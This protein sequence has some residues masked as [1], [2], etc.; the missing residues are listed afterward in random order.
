MPHANRN[1]CG[2]DDELI[3]DAFGR[4]V[5][6]NS[7]LLPDDLIDVRMARL[8]DAPPICDVGSAAKIPRCR[9]GSKVFRSLTL[10]SITQKIQAL[11]KASAL[12]EISRVRFHPE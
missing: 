7:G 1:F 12:E 9:P 11:R 3:R 4:L 8:R 10:A 6:L 5:E 2:T